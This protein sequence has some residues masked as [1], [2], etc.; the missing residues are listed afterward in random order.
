M[1]YLEKADSKLLGGHSSLEIASEILVIVLY[2]TSDQIRGGHAIGSLCRIETA[3][4]LDEC[5]DIVAVHRLVWDIVVCHVV[6]LQYQRP[7][8][9]T[10][11]HLAIAHAPPETTK[12]Q[13]IV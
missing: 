9:F 6:D 4:V 13:G 5:I 3:T 10:W 12:L 8:R 1:T 7:M 2:N 11:L